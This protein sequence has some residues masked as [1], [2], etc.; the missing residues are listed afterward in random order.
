VQGNERS[1]AQAG[2][3]GVSPTVVYFETAQDVIQ[4][5]LRL[6]DEK[7]VLIICMMWQWWQKRNKQNKEGKIL[8]IE[9]VWRQAR[10]WAGECM[11]FCGT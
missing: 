7:K 9:K 3:D 11:Q 2:D 6:E 1:V 10:Y 4:Q 8:M 5:I